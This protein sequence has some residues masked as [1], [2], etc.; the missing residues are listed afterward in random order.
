MKG[1]EFKRLMKKLDNIER[2]IKMSIFIQKEKVERPKYPDLASLERSV[3][4]YKVPC[5]KEYACSSCDTRK[6]NV[7]WSFGVKQDRKRVLIAGLPYARIIL[8][9]MKLSDLWIIAS[10][11][12]AYPVF[13]NKSQLVDRIIK[14]QFVLQEQGVIVETPKGIKIKKIS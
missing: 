6:R 3:V 1:Q 12:K 8:G 9:N 7:C 11:L 4:Q 2:N 14:R 13:G 10:Y 5:N